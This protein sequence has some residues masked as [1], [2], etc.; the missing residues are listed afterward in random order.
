MVTFFCR[1]LEKLLYEKH[2]LVFTAF[3]FQLLFVAVCGIIILVQGE[4]VS[5]HLSEWGREMYGM[6]YFEAKKVRSRS[7]WQLVF[8]GIFAFFYIIVY[9]SGA[10]EFRVSNINECKLY[11]I[12]QSQSNADL[13]KVVFF[14]RKPQIL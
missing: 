1:K 2:L 6:Q 4:N 7:V 13:K 3:L 8:T 9:F 12:M 5:T 14:F 10:F 11:I